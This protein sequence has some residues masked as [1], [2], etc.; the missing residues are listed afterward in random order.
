MAGRV[1]VSVQDLV[2]HSSLQVG[3][4]GRSLRHQTAIIKRL[5]LLS[6]YSRVSEITWQTPPHLTMC[7]QLASGLGE[8]IHKAGQAGPR[9]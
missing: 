7:P 3:R 5:F 8:I 1:F 9:L 4:A 6:R 2:A